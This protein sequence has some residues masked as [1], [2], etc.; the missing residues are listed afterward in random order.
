M[1]NRFFEPEGYVASIK[2]ATNIQGLAIGDPQPPILPLPAHKAAVLGKLLGAS[3][4]RGAV[5][6]GARC[7]CCLD[8]GARTRLP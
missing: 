1:V 3:S 4:L 2:A 5:P 8:L 7:R 6:A